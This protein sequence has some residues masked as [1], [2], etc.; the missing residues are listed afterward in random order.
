MAK[1]IKIDDRKPL[2][3]FIGRMTEGPV[4]MRMDEGVIGRLL[5][6]KNGPKNVY[7]LNPQDQTEKIILT[8]DNYLTP[9]AELFAKDVPQ[10]PAEEVVVKEEKTE[11][12][13]S[14]EDRLNR[15]ANA[16]ATKPE[17]VEETPVVEA[18]TEEVSEETETLV[19][20]VAE[21]E[22]VKDEVVEEKPVEEVKKPQQ[23][24]YRN[25]NKK[26]NNKRK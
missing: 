23:Q 8:L 5:R 24:Q 19:E 25:N 6:D 9:E 10:K 1:L 21:Q 13:T 18:V 26:Y 16:E 2:E 22:E 11:R 4:K 15:I 17:V 3:I 20:E 14:I 7:A 12:E